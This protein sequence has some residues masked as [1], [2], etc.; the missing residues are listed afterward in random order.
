MKK[1]SHERGALLIEILVAV[2]IFGAI[3]AIGAQS[4]VVSL[5]A[6]QVASHKSSGTQL[7]AEMV[8]AA[9]AASDGNWQNV[10]GLTKGGAHYHPELQG[11][12]WVIVSGDETVNLGNAIFTRYFTV[13][14]VSRDLSTRAIET[15]YTASHD[16]PSTQQ[17]LAVVTSTTTGSISADVYLFRWR[18][19]VCNQTTWS[20]SGASGVKNCP[21]ASYVS[22]TNITPGSDLQLC[23]GGC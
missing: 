8:R 10:Y 23:S 21:D 12:E 13:S 20:S 14:N 22:T 1:Y 9:R 6:N 19:K 4:L 16:D 7:L 5:K 18:N 15:T 17:I 11:S 3:A 2:T